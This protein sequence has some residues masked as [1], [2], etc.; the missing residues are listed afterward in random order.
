MQTLLSLL[1]SSRISGLIPLIVI[2]VLIFLAC[3]KK[4]P[5]NKA[6]IITGFRDK[7]KIL[8]GRAGFKIP[9]LERCDELDIGQITIGLETEEYVPTKDFINIQV[10]AVV[11]I[12]VDTSDAGIVKAMQHFLNG[13]KEEIEET[14]S[15]TLLGNLREIVG[16]MELKELCQDKA[17]FSEEVKS[18]AK[19]DMESLGLVILAFNVQTVKDK[20]GLISNLGIENTEKIRQEAAIAKAIAR[21]NIEIAEAQAKD[22]SNEADTKAELAIAERNN[23]LEIRRSELRVT[24]DTKRAAA[25]AAFEIQ[26][27]IS[28]KDL[29]ISAQNAEIA[30]REK[31][32]ELQQREA[33]VA[34]KRLDAQVKKKAEAEKYAAEQEADALLYTRQKEAEAKLFEQEKEA[35]AIRK[36]GEAEAEAIR[37]KG[38]A[39]AA[40]LDKKADAMKKYGQ[41]AI[42][43]MIVGILPDM[44]K[45][46]AEPIS[47]IDKVTVIGGNSDGVSDVAGNVPLVLAKVMESVKETTGFDLAEVMKADTYDAKVNRKVELSGSVPVSSHVEEEKPATDEDLADL[48]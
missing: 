31:E 35:I 33:E 18:K 42:L 25:D 12:A 26:A 6:Y 14:A 13:G 48:L 37:L 1:F 10:E 9:F 29:E 34:E 41:A 27:A 21:R 36:T 19:D 44:A 45:A 22:E 23:A 38:E 15:K 11:Q 7:P 17:K 2:L 43:E 47:A 40:A 3:L 24:E 16:T 5:S 8:S 39:E 20:D 30:K 32:I 46:I 4:A 28:R